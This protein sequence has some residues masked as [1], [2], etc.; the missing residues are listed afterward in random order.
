MIVHVSGTHRNRRQSPRKIPTKMCSCAA[1]NLASHRR[2][3]R[4]AFTFRWKSITHIRQTHANTNSAH[5]R[6]QRMRLC[7]RLSEQTLCAPNMFRDQVCGGGPLLGS[8]VQWR[9][10]GAQCP[11]E[12]ETDNIPVCVRVCVKW[13]D[14]LRRLPPMRGCQWV[15]H[16]CACNSAVCCSLILRLAARAVHS[17]RNCVFRVCARFVIGFAAPARMCLCVCVF[18]RIPVVQ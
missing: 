8:I 14:T 18:V 3:N 5:V 4:T 2:N 11:G 10:V 13:P 16:A 17:E 15:V 7:V 6:L 12:T 1:D 9:S